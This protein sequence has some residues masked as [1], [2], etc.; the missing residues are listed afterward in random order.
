MEGLLG[1]RGALAGP[2]QAEGG[3]EFLPRLDFSSRTVKAGASEEE[4]P[5][6]GQTLPGESFVGCESD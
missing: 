4:D 5:L 3:G 1:E 6:P 2:V